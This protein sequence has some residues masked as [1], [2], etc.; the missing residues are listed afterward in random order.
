MGDSTSRTQMPGFQ[1]DAMK[2]LFANAQTAA[3][4]VQGL[5]VYQER[6]ADQQA[7]DGLLRDAS[8]SATGIG[9]QTG[10]IADTFANQAIS[11]QVLDPG[12]TGTVERDASI[13]ASINPIYRMFSEQVMPQLQS[14]HIAQGSEGGAREAIQ[15][16][17]A[18]RDSFVAPA[19]EAAM[20]VA[21]QDL[22]R[23]SNMNVQEANL[24]QQAGQ[25][26]PGLTQSGFD[27]NMIPAEL[28]D[29][30]GLRGQEEGQNIMDAAIAQPFVG[31]PELSAIIQNSVGGSTT[32]SGGGLMSMLGGLF[33]G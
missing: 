16:G 29:L 22:N 10:Q 12:L 7:A 27:L 23:R 26:A 18:T 33:G 17:Q 3:N 1:K 28:L 9:D 2:G 8:A 21:F 19:M 6:G 11:G 24:A 4:S 5:P 25:L 32:S 14:N 30:I 31:L 13:Q 15:M 20:N